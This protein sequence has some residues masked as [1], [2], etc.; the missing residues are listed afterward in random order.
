MDRDYDEYYN[1]K[2]NR[3]FSRNPL[4]FVIPLILIITSLF[5]IAITLTDM[6]VSMYNFGQ[7]QTNSNF[8]YTWDENPF[9]PVR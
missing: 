1:A 5:M 2:V 4:S 3:R 8:V 6:Y 9:W 7:T